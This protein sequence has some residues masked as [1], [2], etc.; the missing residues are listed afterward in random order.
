MSTFAL[1]HPSVLVFVSCR[2]SESNDTSCSWAAAGKPWTQ[3]NSSCLRLVYWLALCVNLTQA[4]VITQKGP[5]AGE[6]P[7]W[8]P[9]VRH[10]L[11]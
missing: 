5:S 7:P 2:R 4:E 3:T 6:M 1:P 9:A 10:F 8:D 11:N